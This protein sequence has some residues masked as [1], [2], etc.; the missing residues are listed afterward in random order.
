MLKFDIWIQAS[1]KSSFILSLIFHS[2]GQ[3]LAVLK[4]LIVE[5][6]GQN[7]TE[8]VEPW[9]L[10]HWAWGHRTRQGIDESLAGEL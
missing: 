5:I 2:V 1:A 4:Y 7:P 6:V 9:K 8:Q 10:Y 3:N